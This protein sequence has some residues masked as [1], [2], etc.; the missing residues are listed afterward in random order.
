MIEVTKAI[1]DTQ[2][3][4][5]T[6]K[7][8]EA[9]QLHNRA[10][11]DASVMEFIQS[12]NNPITEPVDKCFLMVGF[13]GEGRITAKLAGPRYDFSRDQLN[14]LK[15]LLDV[16]TKHLTTSGKGMRILRVKTKP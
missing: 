9:A 13:D 8:Q 11:R 7:R 6:A 14:E 15:F 1:G 12:V 4:S 16:C 2:S 3:N 10:I 5:S